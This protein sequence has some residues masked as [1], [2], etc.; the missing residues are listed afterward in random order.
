METLLHCG[1][2]DGTAATV[3]LFLEAGLNIEAINKGNEMPLHP[4]AK[5]SRMD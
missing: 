5:H 1:A 2:W 4:D 3:G